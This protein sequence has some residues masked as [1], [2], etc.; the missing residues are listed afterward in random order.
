MFCDSMSLAL[1][2]ARWFIFDWFK[3]LVLTAAPRPE[4]VVCVGLNGLLHL[5]S[6]GARSMPSSRICMYFEYIDS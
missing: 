1:S 4:P 5:L 3:R 2:A 6:F